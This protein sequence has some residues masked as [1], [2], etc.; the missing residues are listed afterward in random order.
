MNCY[1]FYEFSLF[2]FCFVFYVFMFTIISLKVMSIGNEV[3]SFKLKLKGIIKK[4]C[5]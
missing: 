1:G 4:S 2:V 3:G 5:K